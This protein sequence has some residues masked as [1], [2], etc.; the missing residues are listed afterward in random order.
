MTRP[1]GDAEFAE[2]ASARWAAL[3]RTAYLLVHDHALAEDLVQTALVKTYVSWPKLRVADAAEAY[4]RKILVNTA[5]SWFRRK[6]WQKEHATAEL[7]DRGTR[8]ADPEDRRWLVDEVAG[9]PP[10]QRAVVVLRYLEDLSVA[11]TA[12][13]LGISEGTVK[14]QCSDAL[15]RLRTT[16]GPEI[17]PA[18]G[19]HD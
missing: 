3:Y 6:S 12:R 19:T 17:V 15:K 10:R 9:L 2:F 11:E 7:P 18:G 4:T 14:S 8:D 1:P 5:L 16:L 13:I